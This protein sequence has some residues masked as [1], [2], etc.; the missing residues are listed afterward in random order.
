M[1]RKRSVLIIFLSLFLASLGVVALPPVFAFFFSE[2]NS[3]SLLWIR[4][5]LYISSAFSFFLAGVMLLKKNQLVQDIPFSKLSQAILFTGSIL[6]SIVVA[7]LLLRFYHPV[8][9]GMPNHDHLFQPDSTYGWRFISDITAE[10]NWRYESQ[11]LV[12]INSSGFRDDEFRDQPHVAVLGDSFVAGMEVE[13]EERFTEL[14]EKKMD[15]SFRNHGLN[16]YGPTQSLLQLRN[17][18]L[19]DDPELVIFQLY[20]RNDFHDVSGE[21]DWISKLKRPKAVVT[22]DS[23]RAITPPESLPE[24]DA[25]YWRSYFQKKRKNPIRPQ[26]FHLYNLLTKTK[27]TLTDRWFTSDKKTS[28][29]PERRLLS[30]QTDSL[31]QNA[32]S[33]TRVILREMKRITRKANVPFMVIVAP[34]FVQVNDEIWDEFTSRYPH[35]SFNR[36]KLSEMIKKWGQED[37]YRVIDLLPVMRKASDDQKL[38]FPINQHWTPAG[39]RIVADELLPIVSEILDG[40]R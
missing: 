21:Y 19:P 18:I 32:F 29:P 34:S 2:D 11:V 5:V 30:A 23:L 24:V 16:G 28:H 6:I 36:E 4:A 12:S 15:I 3:I 25:D 9:N 40:G 33:D 20:L 10:V 27:E 7:E 26:D 35:E 8:P 14:L 1:H 22:D 31:F 17:V 37:D 39:H 38:Y 13:D